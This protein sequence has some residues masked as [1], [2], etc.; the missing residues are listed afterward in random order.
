MLLRNLFAKFAHH[1]LRRQ[2]NVDFLYYN[3]IQN[4]DASY[5]KGIAYESMMK[6]QIRKHFFLLF[7][8]VWVK[9][10]I[11]VFAFEKTG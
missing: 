10:N 6:R 8:V 2:M 5:G 11:L 9:T 4:P 3:P 1:L 7:T